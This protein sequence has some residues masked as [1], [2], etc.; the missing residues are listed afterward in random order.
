MKQPTKNRK[1]QFLLISN[2]VISDCKTSR[3]SRKL[4]ALHRVSQTRV[5]LNTVR[6]SARNGGIHKKFRI[7]RNI[8]HIPQNIAAC[9]ANSYTGVISLRY[10][11]VCKI[12]H[13]PNIK[14][15]F[16]C[17][18]LEE[19]LG[20]TG[21]ERYKG[22]QHVA[23]LLL[24]LHRTR[25]FLTGHLNEFNVKDDARCSVIKLQCN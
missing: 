3:Y 6:G 21:L 15:H 19:M 1:Y 25:S 9:T 14:N 7:P 20:M 10:Q 16:R 13:P 18:S 5:P 23:Y 22:I 2:H 8:P 17:S 24:P 11:P 12:L 4:I